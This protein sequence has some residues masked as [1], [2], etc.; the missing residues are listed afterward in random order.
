MQAGSEERGIQALAFSATR[1]LAFALAAA[2]AMAIALGLAALAMAMAMAALLVAS[3][4]PNGSPG[5][6]PLLLLLK[7]VA[8]LDNPP[9]DMAASLSSLR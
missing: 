6:W 4:V 1:L 2:L 5:P 3:S 7:G 9:Q 8:P